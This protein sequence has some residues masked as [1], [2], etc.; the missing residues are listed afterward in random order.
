[1]IVRVSELM[2]HYRDEEYDL[3]DRGCVDPERIKSLT[4]AKLG[5]LGGTAPAPARKKPRRTLRIVL[6]A[7]AFAALLSV[8]AYAVYQRTMADRVLEGAYTSEDVQGNPILHYSAVGTNATEAEAPAD[9]TREPAAQGAEQYALYIAADGTAYSSMGKNREYE[10]LKEWTVFKR[11]S[12]YALDARDMLSYADPHRLIYGVAYGV[13]AEKLDDIAEK[14]GLRLM[15]SMAL[16]DTERE[17]FDTLA[18]DSF[19][20][21]AEDEDGRHTFVVFDDGSFEASGLAMDRPDGE[22]LGFNVC[23]AVRGTLTDFLIL[24]GDP[25]LADF[26]TY[27]TASGTEV[28]IALEDTGSFLFADMENCHVTF[29]FYDG[30]REGLTLADLEAA[31]DS[32]DFAALDEINV[33]AVAENVAAGMEQNM[34]ENPGSYRD[35]SG[36]A[37][38]VYDELGDYSLEGLLPEGWKFDGSSVN[39]VEDVAETIDGLAGQKEPGPA[40]YYDSLYLSYA[41]EDGEDRT[42]WTGVN[43]AYERYW[44][45]RDRAIIRNAQAFQNRRTTSISGPGYGWD[46][47][48]IFCTVGGF[49]G[50]YHLSNDYGAH[51]GSRGTYLTWYDTDKQLLFTISTPLEV[52]TVRDTLDLAEAFAASIRDVQGPTP[53]GTVSEETETIPH[54][55][56]GLASA[57]VPELGRFGLEMPAGFAPAEFC[58]EEDPGSWLRA[59]QVYTSGSDPLAGY[60]RIFLTWERRLYED[61]SMEEVFEGERSFGHQAQEDPDYAFQQITCT[62]CTVNGFSGFVTESVY[63]TGPQVQWLDTEH[64]LWFTLRM[65]ETLGDRTKLLDADALVALANT[66]TEQ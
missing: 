14:Y 7:A 41:P 49:E 50:Y 1:M 23:R 36:R 6:L 13:L 64:D 53:T 4:A 32:V 10:A 63:T 37:Q 57:D 17:F 58:G 8:T 20:P 24:G 43:L 45:D 3:P 27:T 12:D 65:D 16:L 38:Q 54:P 19:Y 42:V 30:R 51:L 44:A 46:P 31:T 11:E 52:F 48:L 61:G 25:A 29:W 33:P 39:T 35:V 26:E 5:A 2:N 66:V 47:E 62:D 15:Q 21:V 60:T 34:Q 40:D 55:A 22:P 28:D 56:S 18:L 59:T 9:P